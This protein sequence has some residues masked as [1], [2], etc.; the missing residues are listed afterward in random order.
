MPLTPPAAAVR[1][2][3]ARRQLARGG[4]SYFDSNQVGIEPTCLA[5][6]ALSRHTGSH[7]EV[8][9]SWVAKL[10]PELGACRGLL[11]SW[12]TALA[13]STINILGGDDDAAGIKAARWL[14][15]TWPGGP[16]VALEI[17][18]LTARFGSGRP[19]VALDAEC[20]VIPAESSHCAETTSRCSDNCQLQ[21]A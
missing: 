16:R 10:R 21:V 15:G 9:S 4:W 18:W 7:R 13:L 14:L 2:E 11:G 5:M 8:Q 19:R 3:L 6:L 12:T 20:T 17:Q 1:E